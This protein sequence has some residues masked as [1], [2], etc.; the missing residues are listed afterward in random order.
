MQGMIWLTALSS[1]V[2][3]WLFQAVPMTENLAGGFRARAAW[4]EIEDKDSDVALMV[5]HGVF[6]LFD[7][8]DFVRCR[9]RYVKG[10]ASGK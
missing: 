9:G 7:Q 8:D 2:I 5:R 6:I 3:W 4:I 10:S 1:I